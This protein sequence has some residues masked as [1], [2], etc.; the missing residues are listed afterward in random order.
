MKTTTT[1]SFSTH[2]HPPVI[3]VWLLALWLPVAWAAG[4]GA[5]QTPA[6][7][8]TELGHQADQQQAP[9]KPLIE[10]GQVT[11]NAPLQA[12]RG[13]ISPQGL[14]VESTS[15]SEGGGVFSLVPTRLDTGGASTTVPTGTVFTRDQ[16]VLLDR[17]PV[18]EVFTASAD[19]IRQ[20]FIVKTRPP[21]QGDLSLSLQIEGATARQSGESV[22]L[23]LPGKRE[24]A[25]HS[26][27][28][29]DAGGKVLDATLTRRDD[30]TLNIAVKDAGAIYPL[31]IDPTI[32]DADWQ[33]WNPSMLG[34]NA[35]INAL[36]LNTGGS[37][38]YA[39]GNFTAI[40]TVLA[41]FIAQWDG[42]TWSALGSGVNGGV[43]SLAM[44]GSTLYVGGNFTS[45]GGVTVSN[46]AQWNGSAWS[47]FGS[48]GGPNGT[49]FALAVSSG[50]L[51]VGGAF[52]QVNGVTYNYIV[53][54]NGSAWSSMGSGMDSIVY[55]LTVWNG[56]L[57]A[58]GIF[59]S[60]GG[61]PNTLHIAS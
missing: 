25:Y 19:G 57:Y 45:A 3:W 46:I 53:Q 54:W 31:T 7:P 21:G 28:V 34:A 1:V 16:A 35:N 33:V 11:L 22:L 12:L 20:D 38:L 56:G 9:P 36:T 51:Y 44:S 43:N 32:S 41:N 39:G 49:V 17:G 15:A 40:G 10:H 27:K 26:L 23:T 14:K 5:Q 52:N 61:S 37:I 6:I 24:L 8:L 42:S 30:H 18:Q 58:G 2:L 55:A 4:G 60:A 59:T 48:S 47:A 13:K 50:T 29:T